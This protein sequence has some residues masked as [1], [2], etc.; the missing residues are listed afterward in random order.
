M[1]CIVGLVEGFVVHMGADS[2]GVSG[3]DLQTRS[4]T[5]VFKRGELL[6]G[7]TSSFRMGQLLRFGDALAQPEH[8][9]NMPGALYE[10]MCTRFI[11]SVRTV[12]KTGGFASKKD[13][14]E[15]GGDF[16]VGIRGNLF[17][18]FSDYQVGVNVQPWACVGSGYQVA[19]GAMY[20]SSEFDHPRDRIRNALSAAEAYCSGVRGPFTVMSSD[21]DS[22]NPDG[23]G[24]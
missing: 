15:S 21:S 23:V 5:K 3:F 14:I 9:I 2:A 19:N 22:V 13:E 11:D 4:D 20:A 6:I 16:L 8:H 12:L 1:T 17:T 7:I 18:V 10:F 24:P